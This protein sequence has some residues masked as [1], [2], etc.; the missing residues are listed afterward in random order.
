M[1]YVERKCDHFY[2]HLSS[3]GHEVIAKSAKG[4]K[5]GH[6]ALITDTLV[7]VDCHIYTVHE[8]N[9]LSGLVQTQYP[10]CT[11]RENLRYSMLDHL[12]LYQHLP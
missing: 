10:R 5:M 2:A 4:I 9:M 8:R 3:D 1:N 6:V 7:I 12:A 11:R